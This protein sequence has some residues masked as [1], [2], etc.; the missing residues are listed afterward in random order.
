[1]FALPCACFTLFWRCSHNWYNQVKMFLLIKKHETESIYIHST[2]T[3]RC[4]YSFFHCWYELC[5]LIIKLCCWAQKWQEQYV[6]EFRLV[7]HYQQV[8]IHMYDILGVR[9]HFTYHTFCT[10]GLTK[11][12]YF[13]QIGH[14]VHYISDMTELLRNFSRNGGTGFCELL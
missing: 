4:A 11:H 12:L 10:L 7:E 8:S 13:L 5:S 9:P 1:M 6:L 2:W 14:H 3:C